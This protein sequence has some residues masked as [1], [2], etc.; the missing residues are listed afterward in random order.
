MHAHARQTHAVVGF[1]LQSL[2]VLGCLRHL[3]WVYVGG[4][5]VSVEE[6]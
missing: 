5:M 1:P 2:S 3:I 4:C 6:P